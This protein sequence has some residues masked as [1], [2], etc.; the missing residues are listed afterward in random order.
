MGWMS[1]YKF[2]RSSN[3]VNNKIYR[4]CG[5]IIWGSIGLLIILL[6]LE[7]LGI[8]FWLDKY[9]V[10]ILVSSA[11]VPFGISWLIK[12]KTIEDIKALKGK[13]I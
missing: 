5:N 3:D 9:Y 8:S 12:G 6:I 4:F 7:K 10:I 11:M 2:T 13:F 1:K